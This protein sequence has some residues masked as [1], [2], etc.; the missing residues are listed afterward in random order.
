MPHN[1]IF[2][3]TQKQSVKNISQIQWLQFY[4]FNLFPQTAQFPSQTIEFE[5]PERNVTSG[6]GGERDWDDVS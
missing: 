6:E 2:S 4:N 5:P 3:S 1:N